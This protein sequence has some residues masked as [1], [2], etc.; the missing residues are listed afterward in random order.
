VKELSAS[1][2]ATLQG[3]IG[4]TWCG[5]ALGIAFGATVMYGGMGFALTANKAFVAC[6]LPTF[7]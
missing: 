4:W 2:M 6:I 3:G 7:V 5:I 1:E